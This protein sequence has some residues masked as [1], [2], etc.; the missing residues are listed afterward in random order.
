MPALFARNVTRSGRIPV[1]GVGKR[2]QAECGE[3]L[4]S[5]LPEPG[6]WL[7]YAHILP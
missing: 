5:H 7:P 2:S 1:L 4:A 3:Y 6:D